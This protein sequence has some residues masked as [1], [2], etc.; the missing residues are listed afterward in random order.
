MA[1]VGGNTDESY[2]ITFFF[3]VGLE[4]RCLEALKREPPHRAVFREDPA[5]GEGGPAR[6]GAGGRRPA[7][8]RPLGPGHLEAAAWRPGLLLPRADAELRVRGRPVM[9]PRDVVAA[10]C[11]LFRGVG[12]RGRARPSPSR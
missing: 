6:P 5:A 4:E 7:A 10:S 1:A 9:S 3:G 12:W 2:G 8:G 11:T